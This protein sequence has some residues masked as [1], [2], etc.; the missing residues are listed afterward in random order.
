MRLAEA[1]ASVARSRILPA[2]AVAATLAAQPTANLQR[3]V[4]LLLRGDLE[5]AEAAAALALE[6]PATKP[7]AQA[8]I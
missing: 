4:E 1:K 7:V 3:S 6:D 5:S 2:I 8:M